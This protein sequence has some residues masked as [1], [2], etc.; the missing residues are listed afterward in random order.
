MAIGCCHRS[1]RCSHTPTHPLKRKRDDKEELCHQPWSCWALSL[2]SCF[3]S[4]RKNAALK[5]DWRVSRGHPLIATSNT[6]NNL[7]NGSDYCY[8]YPQLIHYRQYTSNNNSSS[9]LCSMW[10]FL[11]FARGEH[12]AHLSLM[13][14]QLVEFA[15][16]R[17]Y[18]EMGGVLFLLPLPLLFRRRWSRDLPHWS[19]GIIGLRT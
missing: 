11:F 14:T 18:Q 6:Q 10:C 8:C 13:S 19:S 15:C 16:C 9:S 4:L 12:P 1:I 3:F 17:M 2:R 7:E 5:L